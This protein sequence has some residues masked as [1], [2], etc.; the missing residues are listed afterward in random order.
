MRTV[1]DYGHRGTSVACQS[2]GRHSAQTGFTLVEL[3]ITMCVV[4]I[5]AAIGVPS[6]RDYAAAAAIRAQ[7]S[8][9]SGAL[10]LA[11]SEAIKRG[12]VVTLC[13]TDDATVVAPVCAAGDDWS[14]GWVIRQ[15]DAVIQVQ[16][17]YRGKAGRGGSG[18][19]GSGSI[20]SIRFLPTGI[21]Q[22]VTGTLAFRPDLPTSDAAYERLSQR[23]C[24]NATGVTRKC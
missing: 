24:I 15:G 4:A 18:G 8:D 17:A 9:F 6:F 14:A 1:V 13:R 21:A 22:G 7:V 5:L 10:R 2:P 16:E 12:R 3:L 23:I 19:I 20:E 11:R